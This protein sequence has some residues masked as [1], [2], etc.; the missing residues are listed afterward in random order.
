MRENALNGWFSV[1]SIIGILS[2]MRLLEPDLFPSLRY[3]FFCGEPLPVSSAQLWQNAA[4]HSIFE[5]LYG[6]TQ[7]TITISHYRWDPNHAP[8]EDFNDIRR[9]GSMLL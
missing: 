5:N 9:I 2:K 8:V 3:S 4:R 6:P 7:A 1:P